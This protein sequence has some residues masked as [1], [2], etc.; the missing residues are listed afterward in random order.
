MKNFSEIGFSTHVAAVA[1]H[2][3]P[4]SATRI[5]KGENGPAVTTA[6][7]GRTPTISRVTSRTAREGGGSK[8]EKRK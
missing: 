6:W 1:A 2:F 8:K 4:V 5:K 3:F 7:R